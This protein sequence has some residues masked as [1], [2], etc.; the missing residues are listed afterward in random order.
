MIKNILLV[1]AGGFAGSIAR[2]LLSRYMELRIL[3]SFP[4]GTL[5]V[6]IVGCFI[7]GVI[8]GLTV[9]NLASPEIRFLLATG[10]CGGFTTFSTFSYESLALLRDGQLWFAFLYMAGSML[11]GLAAVWI[12]LFIMSRI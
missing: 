8:Y 6:N 7:I 4:F 9:R 12:G 3:T 5:T 1:G 2:Y 11:A 10:F